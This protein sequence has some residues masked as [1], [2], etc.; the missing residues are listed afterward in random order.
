M[1]SSYIPY[2]LLYL[3]YTN[4]SHMERPRDL[5]NELEL[6]CIVLELINPLNTEYKHC[7]SN[8]GK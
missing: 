3:L 7:S 5:H 1:T 6:E 4:C 8:R 2:T